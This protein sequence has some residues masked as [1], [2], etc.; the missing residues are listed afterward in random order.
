MKKSSC[1]PPAR[2]IVNLASLT[3]SL[4]ASA[5]ISAVVA[6]SMCL[7]TVKAVYERRAV[8]CVWPSA[9][10]ADSPHCQAVDD[11]VVHV[12]GAA[13]LA[14]DLACAL[15]LDVQEDVGGRTACA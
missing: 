1:S 2:R 8:A 5:D 9:E 13:G 7:W 15:R 11:D 12:P 3:S 6:R 4:V 14:L 10:L